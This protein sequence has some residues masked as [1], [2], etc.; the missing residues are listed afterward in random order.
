[1]ST[2]YT[3]SRS[4]ID[5]L[6]SALSDLDGFICLD[7]ERGGCQRVS[8]LPDRQWWFPDQPGPFADTVAD[9]LRAH[10]LMADAGTGGAIAGSLF[11]EA[12]RQ[13]VPGFRSSGS[14]R[15]HVGWA[16]LYLWQLCIPLRGD[17]WLA[18]HDQCTDNLKAR[19]LNC[20]D[21]P[22]PAANPQGFS[23]TT[24]FR[25]L[26]TAEDYRAGVRRI[27]D[28]IRAGDCYQANLAQAFEGRFEGSPWQAWRA[29]TA[30]IPVPHGGYLDTGP[31]QLL[32][33][34]PELFLEIADNRVTSKPI[35][36]T[37]PRHEHP[38][39]DR[40]LAEELATHPKDRAENLMIVDL[41]RNDLSHFCEAFSVQVPELFSIESFRNVH[42]LVSTVTGTLKPTITPFEAMLSAFPGGSITGAPKR[43]AMEIID[44]LETF[45]REPYCGS[46]FWWGCDNRLESNIAIRTLQ[47]LADG[48][49]RAW[50]GCGIV[51]DSD[52]EEEYQESLTKIRRLLSTLEHP[53][54]G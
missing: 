10:Q 39:Q 40:A 17:G 46:L 29:L 14:A 49:V 5:A 35:K 7:T 8:A 33:V 3:V 52:P 41:I 28:Y 30:A 2:R 24:P 37:R 19:I 38:Q 12:G 43:R 15:S 42:Q 31:W 4:R 48:R 27:L 18:F 6:L 47:T 34:S 53:G 21:S 20:V 50:A 54:Q 13:T 51:A 9:I 32:S 45:S 25:P 11:Y 22:S 26:G 16:G 36:G 1:M 44:E 23:I